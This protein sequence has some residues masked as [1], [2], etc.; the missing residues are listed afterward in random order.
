MLFKCILKDKKGY[1]KE[2][3]Y[4]EGTSEQEVLESLNLFQW[5]DGEWEIIDPSCNDY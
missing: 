5:S 3:F 1:I 4:R 2:W